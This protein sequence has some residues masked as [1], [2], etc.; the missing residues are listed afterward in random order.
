MKTIGDR[1]RSRREELG[2]SQHELAVKLGYKSRSSINK[3][4]LNS[5][6]LTQSKIKAIADAL[7]VS[8]AYIMGWEEAAAPDPEPPKNLIKI[9][10]R[11]GSII[12]RHLTDSQLAAVKAILDQMPDP[13][14]ED[15]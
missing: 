3:I 6:N 14:N 7:G 9:A 1:I 15:L 4:E 5:Q 10:G 2:I 11:D 13:S 8:P 12:E